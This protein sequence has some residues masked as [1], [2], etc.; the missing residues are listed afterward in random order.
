MMEQR[1]RTSTASDIPSVISTTA[2]TMKTKK[3]SSLRERRYYYDVTG[4]A[5]RIN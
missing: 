2:T 4:K 5:Q 1:D 3:V